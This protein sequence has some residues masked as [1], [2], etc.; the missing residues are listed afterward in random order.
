ML[1]RLVPQ[2]LPAHLAQLVRKELKA[3]QARQDLPAH[4]ACKAMLGRQ[5]RRAYKVFKVC[6]A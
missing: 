5:V 2:A 4:K 6:K 1:A 3:L